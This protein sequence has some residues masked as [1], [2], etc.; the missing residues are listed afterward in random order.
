MS[1]SEDE[2]FNKLRKFFKRETISSGDFNQFLGGFYI[3]SKDS[4]K[5]KRSLHL[6]GKIKLKN[7]KI[8]F[9]E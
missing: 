1:L 6:K 5:I 8:E 9:I 3:N 7:Q 2:I 4:F